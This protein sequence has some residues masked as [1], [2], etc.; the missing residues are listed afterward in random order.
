MELEWK[1]RV[2][3]NIDSVYVEWLGVD[4]NTGKIMYEIRPEEEFYLVYA[5]SY[6]KPHDEL[7]QLGSADTRESAEELCLYHLNR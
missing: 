7:E 6:S 2:I 3:N 4:K 5:C 1:N